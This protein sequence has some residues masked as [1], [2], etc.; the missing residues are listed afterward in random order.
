M[1]FAIRLVL[2]YVAVTLLVFSFAC[3]DKTSNTSNNFDKTQTMDLLIG[4][5]EL[6]VAN[7]SKDVG[8]VTPVLTGHFC[9]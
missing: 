5:W 8:E 4:K 7:S 3:T 6:D 1:R 9:C 2:L